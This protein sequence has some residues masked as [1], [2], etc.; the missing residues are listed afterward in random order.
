MRLEITPMG[1]NSHQLNTIYN[2][3][4]LYYC[5]I[6]SLQSAYAQPS[7]WTM[8]FRIF[9]SVRKTCKC[10]LKC[11]HGYPT[12]SDYCTKVSKW[13]RTYPW[14]FLIEES[15]V[16]WTIDYGCWTFLWDGK[17]GCRTRWRCFKRSVLWTVPYFDTWPKF[18]ASKLASDVNVLRCRGKVENKTILSNF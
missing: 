6:N 7:V 18:Y 11:L 2:P 1:L 3:S 4:I 5:A 13:P 12:S 9:L 10:Q 17:H 14:N 15:K 8:A 16:P